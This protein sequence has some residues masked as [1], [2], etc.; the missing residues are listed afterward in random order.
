MQ[1]KKAELKTRVKNHDSLIDRDYREAAARASQSGP[2][3]DTPG[4][5]QSDAV[6]SELPL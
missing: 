5:Y 4:R 2:V 1:V 3:I 6:A